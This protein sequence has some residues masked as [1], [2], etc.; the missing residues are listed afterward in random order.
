VQTVID[1]DGDK[2]TSSIDL[3][4]GVFQ[5]EDD[6][7]NSA[8]ATT[9]PLTLVL[10][11]TRPVGTEEDGDSDP[12]G[13]DTVKA[14]FALSFLAPDYGSDGAGSVSYTLT[15]TGV[16][17]PYS[18]EF[19]ER[20]TNELLITTL[21]SLKPKGGEAGVKM[22]D[23]VPNQTSIDKVIATVDT[24]RRTLPKGVQLRIVYDQSQLVSSALGGVARAVMV[25]GVF[26]V[27]VILVL[28]GNVRAALLVTLTIPLS[29]ALSGLLLRPLGVGLNTMTLGGLAI[30]VGLL[31]DAAIIM[32]ENILHRLSGATSAGAS[33]GRRQM[34]TVLA[35]RHGTGDGRAGRRL[36]PA[37]RRRFGRLGC[38]WPVSRPTYRWPIR[39]AT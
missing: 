22:P 3:G 33:R 1:A 32:V 39:A 5:I 2:D 31:V 6:G 13:R 26:V 9:P 37:L 14:N 35:V 34:P 28:L 25:G 24:F 10:D 36:V 30:A 38:P 17:V 12:A 19:R 16:N 29:I 20:E 11:E 7:P 15:L 27:L 18:A 23:F 21:A 4:Q 8:V